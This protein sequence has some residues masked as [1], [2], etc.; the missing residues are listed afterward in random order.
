MQLK[1]LFSNLLQAL[2]L[3]LSMEPII[4][5]K[6]LVLLAGF[7]LG[8]AE[9]HGYANPNQHADN[10]DALEQMLGAGI[11]AISIVSYFIHNAIVEHAKIKY[12]VPGQAPGKP[13]PSLWQRFKAFMFKT[14]NPSGAISTNP[15]S[16]PQSGGSGGGGQSV[17]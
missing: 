13:G 17:Q 2:D 14:P 5:Q 15:Q 6:I 3:L 16:S 7:I 9:A 1:D 10:L 8:Y 11:T 12:G 4:D